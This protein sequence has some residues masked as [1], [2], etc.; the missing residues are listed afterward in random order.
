MNMGFV[1][2]EDICKIIDDLGLYVSLKE[3]AIVEYGITSLLIKDF[4]R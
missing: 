2:N 4:H 1:Q 3:V